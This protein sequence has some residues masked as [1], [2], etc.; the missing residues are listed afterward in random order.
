MEIKNKKA[1]YMLKRVF[2]TEW[3]EGSEEAGDDFVISASDNG[4]IYRNF[5]EK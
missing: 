3:N 4:I 1:K 2:D 5:C